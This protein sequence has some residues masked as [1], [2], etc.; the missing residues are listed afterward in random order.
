M[1]RISVLMSIYKN[2]NPVFFKLCLESLKAQTMPIDE[3][4]LIEDGPIP[5]TLSDLI[6]IYRETLNIVSVKIPINKGL[7]N[8][9]NFG[10]KHCSSV[11]VARMDTDDIAYIDRFFEQIKFMENN[12]EID[13]CGSFSTE[14]N[15][16]GEEVRLR[17]MPVDHDSIVKNLW[18]NPFIHPSVIF[19]RERMLSIGGYDATLSRRQDYELWFRCAYNGFKLANIPKPLLYY[20]FG[21]STHKKQPSRVCLL[22]GKIGYR[23]TR[24][25]GLGYI[26]ALLC[27]IPYIRSLLPR[28][29]EHLMYNALK[30]I[31]PR[32][33]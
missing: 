24:K 15:E 17:K 11:F 18:A 31:D 3:L 9:L 26:K 5:S 23:G 20:R 19:K 12:P 4:V 32:N 21:E 14:I 13:L 6:E 22:Q 16:T 28:K 33:S 8:A 2:E 25:A 7:G 1:K 30:K 27:Y 10:L 29:L